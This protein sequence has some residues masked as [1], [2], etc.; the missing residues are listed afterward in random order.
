MS[1][2]PSKRSNRK[3]VSSDL[4]ITP[5]ID[6]VTCLMFFLLMFAGMIPF[7][8]IDA[9]LPKIATSAAEMKQAEKKDKP[10]NLMVFIRKDM[11]I[12]KTDKT[13]EKQFARTP[14]GSL[15]VADIHTHFIELKT[16]SP[17]DRDITLVPENE[18]KYDVLVQVMDTAREMLKG[19]PGWIAGAGEVQKTSEANAPNVLF[20]DVSIG[21]I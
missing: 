3:G 21:G 6:M 13:G 10:L 17:A 14:D 19:D 2:S 7:A 11:V 9:P 1:G 15:P 8:F 12:V 18:T 5:L 20:P 16:G 4:N